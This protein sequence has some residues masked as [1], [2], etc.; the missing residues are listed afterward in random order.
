MGGG[1]GT[2]GAEAVAAVVASAASGSWA[3]VR[4][5]GL[6]HRGQFATRRVGSWPHVRH[7]AGPP[8]AAP[9][10]VTLPLPAHDSSGPEDR[11]H[12]KARHLEP[13]HR[14]QAAPCPPK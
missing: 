6:P 2:E 9:L 1:G 11:A 12:P 10:C 8:V 13:T 4:T 14:E 3:V 5:N 7:A